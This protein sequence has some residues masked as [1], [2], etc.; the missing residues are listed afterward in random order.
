MRD[1]R[2]VH[3]FWKIFNFIK[4]LLSLIE[5]TFIARNN[6]LLAVTGNQLC[7]NLILDVL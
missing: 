4:L 6:P 2:Y 7:I 1:G 3:N 5:E